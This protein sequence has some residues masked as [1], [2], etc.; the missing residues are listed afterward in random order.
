MSPTLIVTCKVTSPSNLQLI[1]NYIKNIDVPHLSQS[2]SYLKI[3]GILYYL[4]DDL[5][6]CLLSNNVK[7]IIK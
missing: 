2:K 7:K 4:Y 1:E 3:I 5:S 6:K